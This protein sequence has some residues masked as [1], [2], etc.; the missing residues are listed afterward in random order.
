MPFH[1]RT[2][3]C[4]LACALAA[5]IA[6]PAAH[7]SDP[8]D[9]SE[10]A[11]TVGTYNIHHAQGVD[12]R[13]DL[14]RI[15]SE[16][17]RTGASVIGLQEVDRHWSSR[18]E[19]VDQA[20]WLATRL[21]M[22]VTYGANLDLEPTAASGGERRQYGTAIL[23]RFPIRESRNTLLPRP[24]NGE[25][26]GLLEAVFKVRGATVRFANTHLQHN[27]AVERTAQAQRIAELL[28]DSREPV[29]LVGDLNARPDAPELTPLFEHYDDA[30]TEGG[31]GDGFTYPAESPN[32]RIDYVL[33]SPE[34]AVSKA[35][36]FSTLASDHLPLTADVTV[37]RPHGEAD[38]AGPK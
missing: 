14:E 10:P 30:W 35:T 25:Q 19:F 32:A 9:A 2:V 15:A 18:S 3:V 20:Q 17:E 11:L 28:A 4:V 5:M 16:I 8:A 31:T 23:S 37:P 36:V 12:N 38:S 1:V 6:A 27:S 26:R 34:I 22:D 21:K 13:L 24:Q 33:V 29:V 7:A